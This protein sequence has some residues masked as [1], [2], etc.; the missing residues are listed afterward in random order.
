MRIPFALLLVLG[1]CSCQGPETAPVTLAER[2]AGARTP[3]ER[4]RVLL[5][6]AEPLWARRP[7][8]ATALL[9]RA[10]A[11]P[12]NDLDPAT[13]R[14]LISARM[15][16]ATRT[17]D[18]T[19][20]AYGLGLLREIGDA[21][22]L[23]RAAA[24]RMLAKAYA[25]RGLFREA[26][27][28]LV[29][30]IADAERSGDSSAVAG[31]GM[32]RIH[33]ALMTGRPALA[34]A[35]ARDVGPTCLRSADSTVRVQF[36]LN[37]ANA[38]VQAMELD[39]ALADLQ[40][41]R[42]LGLACR[43]SLGV[44]ATSA[45]LGSYQNF[46]GRLDDAHSNLI[47]AYTIAERTH[48]AHL[49]AASAFNLALVYKQTKQYA[50]AIPLLERAWHLADSIGKRDLVPLAYGARA[51]LWG[52]AD[53]VQAHVFGIPEHRRYDTALVVL[54][55]A[56]QQVERTGN[57]QWA[58]IF[59]A[60]IAEVLVSK[61]RPDEAE[62]HALRAQEIISAIGDPH[63]LAIVEHTLADIAFARG[64]WRTALEHY[65]RAGAIDEALGLK[66]NSAYV[67]DRKSRVLEKLGRLPEALSTGR[68]ALDAH[69]AYLSTE[70]VTALARG[71]ERAAA[72]RQQLA[73]SLRAE[74]RLGSERDQRTI[75]ELSAARNRATAWGVGGFAMLALGGGAFAWRTQ[76]KRRD[77]EAA[78]SLAEAHQRTADERRRA[79]EFQNAALRAQMD[80][81]FISNTLNAVNARLYTDDPDAA[82][83][84][85]ARFAQWIRSML[86]NSQH[87]TISLKDDL[88]AL[89]T[90]L[91]LQRMRLDGRFDFTVEVDPAI[92][93][94]RVKV[95]PLVVQPLLE[96]AI[97]HGVGPLLEGGR[98]TLAARLRDGSLVLSVED[99]GVGRQAAQV[100][101]RRHAKSSLSMGIIRDQL[102]LLRERTGRVAELRTID[103]PKGTRV[104]VLLPV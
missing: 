58:G 31:G 42:D 18:T 104:E 41:A 79:A 39:S 14:T 53:S 26:D 82:S 97:E 103:L 34:L 44:A 64:E 84:L 81:H 3:D 63:M 88:E 73:D 25:T 101:D 55:D 96:N 32:D 52:E 80:E 61:Q 57:R 5:A 90:Y 77:A 10:D 36:L 67:L 83:E 37:R 11:E 85:L 60:T 76:R 74:Q 56:L 7:D 92:D 71:E 95:P 15:R 68:A 46:L 16:W 43:D 27:S 24:A 48:D 22:P 70:N 59:E 65:G 47:L 78:R 6:T 69:K 50:A 21:D 102:Q 13:V 28:L 40:H 49:T 17:K 23:S 19:A 93:A 9:D 29:L 1:L 99:N 20:V 100:A 51:V 35:I 38:R 86:E 2:L 45:M 87:P 72:A 8:S 89:R 33:T 94:G 66:E 30:A 98:I 54:K 62:P 75:A 91:E 4:V 12:W